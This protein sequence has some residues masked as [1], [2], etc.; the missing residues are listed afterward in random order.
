MGLS[1][2][3]CACIMSPTPTKCASLQHVTIFTWQ[4]QVL[5][6]AVYAH[7]PQNISLTACLNGANYGVECKE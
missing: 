1:I 3:I 4:K 6:G 7:F 2:C 5:S